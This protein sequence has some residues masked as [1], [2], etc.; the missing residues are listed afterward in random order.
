MPG[1]F[2]PRTVRSMC[3]FYLSLPVYPA[4]G[5]VTGSYSLQ[6]AAAFGGLVFGPVLWFPL[7]HTDWSVSL[8]GSVKGGYSC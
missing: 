3:L 4:S 7:L 6:A 1:W 2:G 8:S 5:E